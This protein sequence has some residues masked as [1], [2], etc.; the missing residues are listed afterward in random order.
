MKNNKKQWKT[1]L[2]K[3]NKK[4]THPSSF[5]NGDSDGDDR[6]DGNDNSKFPVEL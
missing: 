4:P 6:G 3:N 2:K 5:P 1:I